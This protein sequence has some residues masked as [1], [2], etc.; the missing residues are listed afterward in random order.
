M[1]C[2]QIRRERLGG[3][4]SFSAA[5]HGPGKYRQT[6]IVPATDG[7]RQEASL[8]RTPCAYRGG[9]YAVRWCAQAARVPWIC[10]PDSRGRYS[11]RRHPV[12][13]SDGTYEQRSTSEPNEEA[14]EPQ[15]HQLHQHSQQLSDDE[16]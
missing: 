13:E 1:V 14:E 15:R 6:L 4:S 12:S 7:R 8:L 5:D 3:W 2:S 10:V 9:G 11:D 16:Q